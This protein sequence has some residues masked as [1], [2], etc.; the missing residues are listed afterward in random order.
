MRERGNAPAHS[1]QLIQT[2]SAKY[3]IPMVRQAPYFPDMCPCDFW[4]FTRLKTQLKGTRFEPRN[5]IIRN[6]AA[7]PYSIRKKAFKNA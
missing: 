1:L 2:F 4:L 7:K 5:D 3:N 6:T